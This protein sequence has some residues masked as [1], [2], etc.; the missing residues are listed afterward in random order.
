MFNEVRVG[1]SSLGA[2]FKVVEVNPRF[3]LENR[4]MLSA[5]LLRAFY[6]YEDPQAVKTIYVV[7]DNLRNVQGGR[8]TIDVPPEFTKP[9][10]QH[11]VDFTT[12]SLEEY[13]PPLIMGGG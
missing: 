5:H 2:C 3:S 9:P 7:S 4:W 11:I 1:N 10:V 13:S 12:F 6:D 8:A